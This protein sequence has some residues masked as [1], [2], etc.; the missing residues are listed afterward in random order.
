MK[1]NVHLLNMLQ[2]ALQH[3]GLVWG[4]RL[5]LWEGEIYLFC[6]LATVLFQCYHVYFYWYVIFPIYLHFLYLQ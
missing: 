2:V 6:G 5:A 3:L 4:I 1:V